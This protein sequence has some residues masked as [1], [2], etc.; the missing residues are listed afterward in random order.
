MN[1]NTNETWLTISTKFCNFI[2]VDISSEMSWPLNNYTFRPLTVGFMI[3]IQVLFGEIF[4]KA[5]T[6]ASFFGKG[7]R[8]F[9]ALHCEYASTWDFSPMLMAQYVPLWTLIFLAPTSVQLETIPR[10]LSAK[11]VVVVVVAVVVVVLV[12]VLVVF[13]VEPAWT[14]MLFFKQVKTSLSEN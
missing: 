14:L 12:V 11:V 3:P 9:N 7:N 10:L 8:A 13:V 1:R 2:S 5:A 4:K 6:S